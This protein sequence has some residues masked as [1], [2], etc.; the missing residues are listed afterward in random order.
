MIALGYKDGNLVL[1][2]EKDIITQT[3]ADFYAGSI[4]ALTLE[5]GSTLVPATRPGPDPIEPIVE[6]F[7]GAVQAA[8]AK[9]ILLKA[10]CLGAMTAYA[11]YTRD[12]A[13][14]EGV[15]F[16]TSPAIKDAISSYEIAGGHPDA[17]AALL[18]AVAA[19]ETPWLARPMGE[20]GPPIRALFAAALS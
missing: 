4:D 9:I 1:Q 15:R 10:Q 13:T 19:D 3:D 6:L 17:A 11:D 5:D 14:A 18:A 12:D 8:Q 20:G 16:A 7:T 2:I